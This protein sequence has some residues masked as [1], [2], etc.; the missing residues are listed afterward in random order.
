MIER[1]QRGKEWVASDEQGEGDVSVCVSIFW[2]MNSFSVILEACVLLLTFA[3]CGIN[4]IDL[5]LHSNL[6]ALIV[7]CPACNSNHSCSIHFILCYF[8]YCIIRI[9]FLSL[10]LTWIISEFLLKIQIHNLFYHVILT[11]IT[12]IIMFCAKQE[13]ELADYNFWLQFSSSNQ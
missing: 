7:L 9:F 11:L 13:Q 2:K 6:P 10:D 4:T 1:I 5:K 8:Y 3:P 12:V